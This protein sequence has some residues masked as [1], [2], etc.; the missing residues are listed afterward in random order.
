MLPDEF[1]WREFPMLGHKEKAEKTFALAGNPNVGKS[2][3][4]N[5]LTGLHQ[6]TGNWPG[7]TVEGAE[8][9]WRRKTGW[10]RLID[11]PGTYTLQGGSGEEERA[12]EGLRNPG[13]DG[14]IVICDATC[15]GRSLILALQILA[16]ELPTLLCVNLMD[17]AERRGISVDPKRLEGEL[18]VPV[19]ALSAGRKRGL[20]TLSR[21]LEEAA[22]APSAGEQTLEQVA[23]EAAELAALV[24]ESPSEGKEG[25]VD[26]ILLQRWAA[27]PI[28][29]L[30]LGLVLWITI[31]GANYPSQWLSQ[32]L[33]ALE[34]P[35]S[36]GLT[37]LHAPAWLVSLVVEGAYRV[38]AWVISVMLPPMAIFFPLFTL[39]EEWGLLPRV[40]F[41]MDHPFS[42]CGGCGRQA[43]TM[44][45]GLGC[46][47]V[48]VSGCQIIASR[49]E[50]LIAILTNCFM[51]CNGRFPTILA[52]ISLFFAAGGSVGE[53]ALLV[54]V[55][56]LGVVATLMVSKTLSATVLKGTSSGMVMEL[57]PFRRP[58]V[59]QVVYRALVDRTLFVLGRAVGTAAPAGVLLWVL[60]HVEVGGA[61]LLCHL[62]SLLNPIGMA[63][64][65]DGVL[66]TAFL[67]GFPANE[68]VLPIALMAYA[69][70][71]SL[72]EPATVAQM[73]QVLM[74]Q[75]WTAGTA[76]C[77]I[78]F[79]LLH[80]PC[81]A[82]CAAIRR[83][84]G[85]W[86]W[87][88]A[89]VVIPTMCGVVFCG[90]LETILK[91]AFKI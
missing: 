62:A 38:V 34:S 76:L 8:G 40:A 69:A 29:L 6:H 86:R 54:G 39:L 57:P 17:E 42:R 36:R 84:T 27:W 1:K 45:M 24:S 80:W 78:L 64:G 26:R 23:Q 59:V 83:E 9:V 31:Q 3:L 20:D 16:L 65:M 56:L 52:L 41:V 77:T 72:G 19:V 33:T 32:A 13:L 51:P 58:Q 10:V 66:L 89:G 81:A 61:S 2:T 11:L 74:A 87:M 43:L 82:T 71:S 73:G 21:R 48:G 88:V 53:T 55:I 85:S 70:G 50:R 12:A 25:S 68:I 49:R 63:L 75:G 46:N 91:I 90:I 22:V 28:L 5:A 44:C 37:A 35:L 14:V 7:K 15:L 60:A 47:A 30:L 4:F 18:G 67:L 79:S